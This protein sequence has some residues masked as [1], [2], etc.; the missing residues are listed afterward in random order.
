[1]TGLQVPAAPYGHRLRWPGYF[2]AE[3]RLLAFSQKP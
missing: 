3:N 2:G 1:M